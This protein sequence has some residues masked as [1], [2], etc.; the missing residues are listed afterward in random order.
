V[1]RLGGQRG[2]QMLELAGKVL[3]NKQD[4][5]KWAS[6]VAGTKRYGT[7]P[8]PCKTDGPMADAGSAVNQTRYGHTDQTH[9]RRDNKAAPQGQWA[10]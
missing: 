10:W 4:L 1:L 7:T 5:H 8:I 6:R 3:V 2:R 9:G